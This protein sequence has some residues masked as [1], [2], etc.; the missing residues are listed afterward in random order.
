MSEIL[1]DNISRVLELSV[2]GPSD[3]ERRGQ[4][5]LTQIL[6]DGNDFI[7]RGK[8]VTSGQEHHFRLSHVQEIIDMESGENVDVA[9][10]RAE[11]GSHPGPA[12]R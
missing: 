10:F 7:L 3:E 11:L 12:S 6:R 2:R 9:E 5:E 8:S 1:F 4:L